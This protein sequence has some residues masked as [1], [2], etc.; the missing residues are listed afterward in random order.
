MAIHE[1]Q[2]LSFEMQLGSHPGFVAQLAPLLRQAFDAQ[3]AFEAQNLHRLLTPTMLEQV[4]KQ[5]SNRRWEYLNNVIVTAGPLQPRLKPGIAIAVLRECLA[6]LAALHREGIVHGDL[7]PGNVMLTQAGASCRGAASG[8]IDS[9][10][11]RKSSSVAPS[12]SR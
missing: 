10:R 9:R 7:K 12:G 6:A 3:P 4:R 11:R 8:E 1:S 2:S 5:V